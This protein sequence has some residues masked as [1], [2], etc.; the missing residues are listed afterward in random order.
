MTEGR[1]DYRLPRLS[2]A[3]FHWFMQNP[4]FSGI[5][6]EAKYHLFT[7][8]R[9]V[10]T[11]R[12]ER[13]ITQGR[14]GNELYII[15]DG[16]C[17]VS[18]EQ[19]GMTHVIGLLGPG[20]IVG[21]MAVVT[22]AAR[23]AHVD[24]ESDLILWAI[25]RESFDKTCDE[26]PELRQFLTKVVATRLAGSLLAAERTIGKYVIEKMVAEGGCSYVYKGYHSSLNMPVAVKMLK[27]D[28][29]MDP[30][31]VEQFR[32]EGRVIAHLNHENI[33]KV[34]DVEEMYR[35]F[36]IIMEFVEGRSLAALLRE[37]EPLPLSTRLS[38]IMQIC[39]GL[40]HAH[41]GGMVHGDVKPG[42]ILIQSDYRAKIVDFG[43]AGPPGTADRVAVATVRYMPPE[44]ITGGTFDERSDIYSLGIMAYE[45]FTGK[46]PCPETELEEILS[47]HLDRDLKDPRAA[48]PDLPEE[49]CGA[50]TRAT[51]RDPAARYSNVGEI[52]RDLA[53]LAEKLGAV[54]S[55]RSTGRLGMT[56]L[57][58]FYREE[59]KPVIEQLFRD[60]SR[61]LKKVG[62]QLRGVSFSN[63]DE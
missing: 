58:V 33:V 3:D 51:R 13:V 9:V 14:P 50:I 60:F 43:C 26:F 32:E 22:G 47:W 35:T 31:F 56:S 25:G 6:D 44:Q 39:H 41:D 49:L 45:L 46:S 29:A 52:L 34:Y 24:A 5:P 37:S 8:I 2:E 12:G 19:G 36:F 11:I 7:K 21:E 15:R 18:L 27:H 40:G 28:M 55:P 23:R 53:P 16:Q 48:A 17:L 63:L 61:E 38:L 4:F 1:G 10:R 57:F 54:T 59:Q 30:A 20:E 42:N 62:A